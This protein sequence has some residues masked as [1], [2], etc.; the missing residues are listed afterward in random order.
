MCK[1]TS[2]TNSCTCPLNE[3]CSVAED[4]GTR[5]ETDTDG[6]ARLNIFL[7]RGLCKRWGHLR[8]GTF[9]R[10]LNTNS[11]CPAGLKSN[12]DAQVKI[13]KHFQKL[14]LDNYKSIY[15]CPNISSAWNL[16]QINMYMCNKDMS[17]VFLSTCLTHVGW[18][19]ILR[20]YHCLQLVKYFLSVPLICCMAQTFGL[21]EKRDARSAG[22][23]G[24][25]LQHLQEKVK[26]T[27]CKFLKSPRY[28]FIRLD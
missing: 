25:T 28:S 18:L 22:L 19:Q 8:R 15:F 12:W 5:R 10:P 21:K 16:L 3:L 17:Y 1:I 7:L 14:L 11:L 4:F 23:W 24:L 20:W 6:F 27:I 2:Q 26:K 9:L 13:Q